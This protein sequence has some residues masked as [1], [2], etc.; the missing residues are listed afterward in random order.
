[1]VLAIR[2]VPGLE[3]LSLSTGYGVIEFLIT[4]LVIILMALG[5]GSLFTMISI[6]MT[7][8]ESLMAVINLLNLPIMFTSAALFPIAIMPDWLATI[9]KYNPLTFAADAIR[10]M[11]FDGTSLYSLE[12]DILALLAFAIIMELICIIISRKALAS[13]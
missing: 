5:F 7:N 4:L 11:A 10:Q 6:R 9:A 1:M 12:L 3:G 13:K 2:F 8:M